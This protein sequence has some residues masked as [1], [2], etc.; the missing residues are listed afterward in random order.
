MR[1]RPAR[2]RRSTSGSVRLQ[3]DVISTSPTQVCCSCSVQRPQ[4]SGQPL[5]GS[6]PNCGGLARQAV[7]HLIVLGH[8]GADEILAHAVRRAALAEIDPPVSL[9]MI[10]AGTTRQA[11]GA[12]ALRDAQESM[13]TELHWPTLPVSKGAA[14]IRSPQT[15]R[16]QFPRQSR[17]SQG[18]PYRKQMTP[19]RAEN[20]RP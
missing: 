12:K 17:R 18:R 10:L 6:T 14:P 9:A 13:V 20:R 4:S 3:A 15:P 19:T 11:L 1:C 5:S 8:V 16:R 7:L 2:S